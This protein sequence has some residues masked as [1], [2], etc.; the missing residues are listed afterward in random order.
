MNVSSLTLPRGALALA[1]LALTLA[2]A[3][4]PIAHAQGSALLI[5][6]NYCGPGNN[7]PLPPIDALDA[8]CAHHDACTP[9][10]DSGLLP[11]CGCNRRLQIEAGAVARNPYTPSETR[12]T[13]QFISNF[14]TAMPCQ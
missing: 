6:G 8:A 1:A 12:Q 5:Y 13:A 3:G 2:L 14:A 11:T 7:A 9:D 10:R 4:S